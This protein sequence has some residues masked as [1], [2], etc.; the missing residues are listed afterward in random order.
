MAFPATRWIGPSISAAISASNG[1]PCAK[2]S[3]SCATIIAGMSAWNTCTSPIFDERRF[4]QARM[5]GADKSI[6][7]T[8]NGKK[9]ILAAVIRGEQ[10]EKFLGKKYVGTKRFGLDGGESM[11]PAL[12]A[13]IKYGGALGV[14]EIVYGMAHRGRLNVLA[15]VMA[16]PYKRDLPRILGR[17]RQSRRRRRFGR[18]EIPPRHQHRPRVRRHQGAYVP[19]AQP[20]PPRDGRSGR[21]RQGPRAAGLPRGSRQARAGA[22]GAHPRRRGLCRPGHRVGMFR[23]LGRA[24]A[25]TPAAASTSSSTTRSASP[26]ARNSR[27]ARPIPP[28]WPKASRRRSST[29]T[30]T[31]P[32]R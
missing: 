10:Y 15:N 5:E 29:S 17:Q 9:A 1:P 8:E 30:A 18:R 21:A 3:K 23:L 4:L 24:A 11:I 12:E 32:K 22:A 16:K 13:V 19:G 7:F 25:T 26:P 6:D 31:I 27:A 20:E 2:W 28:T 14:R